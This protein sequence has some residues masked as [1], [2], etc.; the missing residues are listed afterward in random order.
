AFD[1]S[2]N[3]AHTLKGQVIDERFDW[4][5]DRRPC[6]AP[7]D[8]VFYEA[9]VK[10]LTQLHPGIPPELRGRYAAL[11]HPVMLDYFKKLGVTSVELLPVHAFL[12]D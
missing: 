1:D 10:G 5:D 7:S 9:H 12:D 6:I 3:A 2:D 4:G 8:T 11:A